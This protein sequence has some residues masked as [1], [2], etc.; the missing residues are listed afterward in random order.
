[1]RGRSLLPVGLWLAA[2]AAAALPAPLLAQRGP[3]AAP[4]PGAEIAAQAKRAR[5]DRANAGA[6]EFQGKRI[7]FTPAQLEPG[8]D[9]AAGQV[10]GVLENDVAGDET[11]LPAGRYNLFAAQLADGWHVWAE[12]GGELVKEALRVKVERRPGPPAD[13]R[14]RFRAV[15]WGYDVDYEREIVPKVPSVASI[16]VTPSA[17]SVLLGESKQFTAELRDSTGTLL[18]GRTVT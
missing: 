1:M 17:L 3:R 5:L 6:G 7:V 8:A 18:T 13:K 11:G 4:P 10:I 2:F 9:L 15:G 12:S 14:P 16:T